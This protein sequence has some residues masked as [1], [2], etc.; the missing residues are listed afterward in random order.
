MVTNDK[1]AIDLINA[2]ETRLAK[3]RTHS[4]DLSFNE[5]LDMY[6]GN[7]LNINPD[8]QRLFQWS[9]GAQS[10]FIES[11]LLEMPVPPIYVIEEETRQYLLIDGLQ[12]ISSYLH[13]RGELDATHLEPPIQ[14]GEKLMFDGCDIVEELNGKTFDDLPL[15]LQIKLK[16]AFVRV[17]V[18][19]KGSDSV[20][21]Y[22]MFKRLNTGGRILSPQ[23]LRN[24]MIRLLD[25][26]FANFVIALSHEEIF[27]HCIEGI[28]YQQQLEAYDQELVLRFFALKNNRQAFTHDVSDFLT[29]Y[30]EAISDPSR[31]LTF[32]YEEEK[33]VF[34]KTFSIFQKTL[35]EYSFSYASKKT[36]KLTKAFSI[37]HYE[38]FTLGLQQ[39]L[40]RIDPDNTEQLNLLKDKFTSIKL[41]EEFIGIT[42][43]GGRNSPGPFNQ[44]IGFVE[45]RIADVL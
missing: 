29:D 37:Y 25:D 41:D 39:Y 30:M 33:A 40:D 43:G 4:L 9:Q 12:R 27:K 5:L 14:S 45:S 21:K 36:A 44:R 28:T 6:K 42:T 10:R 8:F 7:E 23:Q 17:E 22:H 26:K 3:L 19:R 13:L 35:G 34:L 16:R 15:A 38:A 18:I 1:S 20:F 2:V 31:A 32:D 24:S 11:L